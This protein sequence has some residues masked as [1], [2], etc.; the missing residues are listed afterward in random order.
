MIHFNWRYSDFRIDRIEFFL[1]SCIIFRSSGF[2]WGFLQETMRCWREFF[3]FLIREL[4]SW[5]IELIIISNESRRI[6]DLF[7][8]VP[9][10]GRRHLFTGEFGRD[11]T[12]QTVHG[13]D[14]VADEFAHGRRDRLERGSVKLRVALHQRRR[15][16]PSADREERFAQPQL[17]IE[18]RPL[19]A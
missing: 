15:L 13:I 5:C 11:T 6:P 3:F 7:G 10:V 4:T 14:Y 12:S 19:V 2:F 18:R 9:G 1:F 8:V 17:L 16:V